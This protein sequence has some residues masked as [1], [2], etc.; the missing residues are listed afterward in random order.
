MN[1]K[2]PDF[3]K[4]AA[5]KETTPP[6]A[7]APPQLLKERTK[8]RALKLGFDG[9]RRR[10]GDVFQM[11]KGTY[12]GRWMEVVPDDTPLLTQTQADLVRATDTAHR[13]APTRLRKNAAD[14]DDSG[15]GTGDVL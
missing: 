15:T 11:E 13:N 10:P 3:G 2:K 7:P 9:I 14:P 5:P 6:A 12:V 1:D 8:V 4:D